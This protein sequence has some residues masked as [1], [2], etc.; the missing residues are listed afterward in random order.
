M[1]TDFFTP[2]GP[3]TAEHLEILGDATRREFLAMLGAAGLL[4]AGGEDSAQGSGSDSGVR[5]VTDD[6]GRTV[7]VPVGAQRIVAAHD[8]VGARALAHGVGLIAIG[9]RGGEV[10]PDI[11]QMFDVTGLDDVGD[12]YE[13]NFEAIAVLNPD[14]ILHEAF[15]G[16]SGLPLDQLA[17]LEE[18]APTL[19]LDN[20]MPLEEAVGR[21]EALFG[22]L[23]AVDLDA[24]R[25]RFEDALEELRSV[26]GD[27]WPQTTVGMIF[28]FDGSTM[29]V[30]GPSDIAVTDILG[31]VGA[32]FTDLNEQAFEEG[33]GGTWY[34][35]PLE[36]VPDG[37]A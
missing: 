15:A 3:L 23:A 26:L 9:T 10:S 29:N 1:T 17:R 37:L 13:L 4:G 25:A 32:T 18:I 2:P 20:F 35:V 8:S 31:R 19:L 28:S 33:D 34:D 11:A 14:L 16:E 7:S 27:Q 5:V 12:P 21:A 30:P 22:D 24:E 6:A 36:L